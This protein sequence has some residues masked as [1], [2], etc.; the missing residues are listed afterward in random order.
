VAKGA[1]RPKSPFRG[2]LDLFYSAA[3][4]FQRS[5][6]SSLH[7]LREVMLQSPHVAL[8]TDF[9][10]LRQATYAALLIEQVTEEET[11]LPELHALLGELL[12]I[13]E[14]NPARPEFLLAFEFKLLALS[15]LAAGGSTRRLSRA[16]SAL[17]E[18]LT[19][20][21]LAETAGSPARPAELAGLAQFLHGFMIYHLG[22]IPS[23]RDRALGG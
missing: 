8:R 22:R 7:T 10:K 9:A 17:A 19:A 2:K 3:F 13:L 23:G 18:S 20:R 1:R 14:A 5:R 16:A 6:R 12:D 15:G 21:S 11:P 4:S